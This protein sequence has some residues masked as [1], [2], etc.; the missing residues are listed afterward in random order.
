MAITSVT[1]QQDNIVDGC[2][3]LAVHSPLR[4]TAIVQDSDSPYSFPD[5]LDVE[6]TNMFSSTTYTGYKAL[7]YEIID[8]KS[9]YIFHSEKI[10]RS[11]MA[12]FDD[13][14]R[15]GDTIEYPPF[16]VRKFRITFKYLGLSDYVD[17][18]AYLASRQNGET[19][20]MTE[21]FNNDDE[22]VISFANREFYLHF[23]SAGI[24]DAIV[25]DG[26]AVDESNIVRKRKTVASIGTSTA[27]VMV[28]GDTAKTITINTLPD[29]QNGLGYASGDRV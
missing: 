29:C 12:D 23:F 2:N 1:I 27:V 11:L 4:F 6:I 16:M 14:D 24:T 18:Y 13:T 25:F 15:D 7:Q 26:S 28:D 17:I 5:Y 3:L 8:D 10:L 9:N 20:A 19:E 22:T 21:M